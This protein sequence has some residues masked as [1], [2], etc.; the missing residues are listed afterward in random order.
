LKGI[1]G[2]KVECDEI[3]EHL[4]QFREKTKATGGGG[5]NGGGNGNGNGNGG[6]GNEEGEANEESLPGH[7]GHKA[8]TG[9]ST[10]P[11]K[12]ITIKPNEFKASAPD[13]QRVNWREV[14]PE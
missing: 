1:G 7:G 2:G 8:F 11:S 14:I 13:S 3:N 10:I 9:S 6:G 4:R 12:D 5:N